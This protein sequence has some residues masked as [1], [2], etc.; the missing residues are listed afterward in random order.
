M[1]IFSMQGSGSFQGLATLSSDHRAAR[2]S[3]LSGPNLGCPLPIK[4]I[5]CGD[6][7]FHA[8]RH[9]MNPYNENRC[10]QT[11]RDGQ[12]CTA[13][14]PF[15]RITFCQFLL[16]I[17]LSFDYRNWNLLLL[18]SSAACG[19]NLHTLIFLNTISFH[20]TVEIGVHTMQLRIHNLITR[21]KEEEG[22][23]V[24]VFKMITIHQMVLGAI[25]VTRMV[26][27]VIITIPANTIL[28]H[29]HSRR[30]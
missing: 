27:H 20:N 26:L 23:F 16:F 15:T 13:L 12:V 30:Y 22:L 14:K 17:L 18:F 9:L 21:I 10:V 8:T 28:S 6:I 2:C 4:W 24:V 25:V 3:D 11:S 5:K 1:L 29:L 7:P 19:K